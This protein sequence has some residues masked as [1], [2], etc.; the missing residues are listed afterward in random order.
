VRAGRETLRAFGSAKR[1]V[2]EAM[3]DFP[4]PEFVQPSFHLSANDQEVGATRMAASHTQ[5]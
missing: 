1:S 5:W 3:V 4:L 2:T